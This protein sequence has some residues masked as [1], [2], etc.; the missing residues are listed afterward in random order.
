MYFC[1]TSFIEDYSTMWKI[2]KNT[3][4]AAILIGLL[5]FAVHLITSYKGNEL[6]FIG[7]ALVILGSIAFIKGWKGE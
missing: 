5:L 2:I 3:G 1:A 7:L 4:A 6:L